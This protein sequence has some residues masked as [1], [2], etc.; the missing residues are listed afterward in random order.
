MDLFFLEEEWWLVITD[1][2]SRYTELVL[3]NRFTSSAIINPCK[4]IFAMHGIPEVVFTDNGSQFSRA[5]CV[6]FSNF[7]AKYNFQHVT[8]SPHYHQ[9]NGMAESAVK[10]IN[11]SLK[12]MG[13]PY[14]PLLAYKTS[15][16]K[17][18]LSPDELL[19]KQTTHGTSHVQ[20][21]PPASDF[22]KLA[23]FEKSA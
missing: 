3:L 9:S 11:G 1:Y 12:K 7:A 18:G 16:L 17:N 5:L 15:L 19:I 2:F 23:A 22:Q 21:K 14:K 10:I 6:E 13:D 8:S 4:S 20:G